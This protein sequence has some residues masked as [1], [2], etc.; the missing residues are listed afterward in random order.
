MTEATDYL[1]Q[2]QEGKEPPPFD[3][4]SPVNS[5]WVE[6]IRPEAKLPSVEEIGWDIFALNL[7]ESGKELTRAV[8]QKSVTPISTGLRLVPPPG[9]Y[10]SFHSIS[11]WADR[12]V[13]VI[14]APDRSPSIGPGGLTIYLFNGSFE[15]HYIPHGH[16][17]AKLLLQPLFIVGVTEI[18]HS[19]Q[20]ARSHG[21]SASQ[22]P[23]NVHPRPRQGNS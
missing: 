12:G 4:H 9:F 20:S 23:Q 19:R 8:H 6:R 5:I 14:D 7:S 22:H 18:D 3:L 16:R 1:K 17:I 21:V 2:L 13:I 10:F 11:Y 15:T